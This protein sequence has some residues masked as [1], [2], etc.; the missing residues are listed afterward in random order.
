MIS[1]IVTTNHYVW[2]SEMKTTNQIKLCGLEGKWFV[3][4]KL[5][6]VFCGFQFKL[7]RFVVLLLD[8]FGYEHPC[9]IEVKK[10]MSYF[11]MM[12]LYGTHKI[13][14][15][16]LRWWSPSKGKFI[17]PIESLHLKITL[18]FY[19]NSTTLE[20]SNWVTTLTHILVFYLYLV[21]FS[22]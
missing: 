2:F 12:W 6:A 9:T 3:R 7:V 11:K 14:L 17:G 15:E 10:W 8:W 22:K 18:L 21:L 4:F 1:I 19:S 5:N 13:T 20:N 16:Q